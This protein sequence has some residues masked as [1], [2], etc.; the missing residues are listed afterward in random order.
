MKIWF[1]SDTHC[2]HEK[3]NVPAVDLVIHCGDESN[4][5]NAYANN[6][7]ARDFL[8][9]FAGLDIPSKIFVPG[10]HS[11]A[12]EQGLVQSM[13]FPGITFLIHDQVVWMG[14][15]I[16]GSPYTPQF[17]EWAYMKP[18]AELD[19]IWKS[20]P[21]DIDILVTHGPPNGILD[22]TRDFDTH[23]N[24]HV[25]S[26]SLRRHVVER[27]KPRIHVFGHLHDEKEIKN[28][29]M[30]A[31]DSIQF[32]NCSTCDIGGKL[33]NQGFVVEVESNGAHG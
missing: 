29:G 11:I 14:V 16:F 20:I 1:I 22:V 12:V 9:W 13:D 4:S 23:S 17:F 31:R 18:R 27:I 32:I 19:T 7:E 21:D 26:K 25:G 3:L 5:R 30:I 2:E 28:C 24:I 8:D 6:Q 15:K 10:N 33:V